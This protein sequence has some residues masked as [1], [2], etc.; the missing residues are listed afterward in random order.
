MRKGRLKRNWIM[1]V[2]G[3]LSFVASI[4]FKVSPN[5]FNNFTDLM[6]ASLAFSSIATALFLA[7]FSLVPAFTNSKFIIAIQDLGTDMKIM[8]RLLVSTLVF[9]SSSLLTFIELL[10]DAN[11]DNFISI[12]F[13]S[14]WIATTVMALLSTFYIILLLMKAFEYYYESSTKN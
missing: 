11:E 6:S 13:T 9:F 8:D 3:I 7:T 14:F 4:V 2:A 5:S 1:I 10:F 12:L